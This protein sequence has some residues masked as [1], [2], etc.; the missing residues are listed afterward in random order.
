MD[1]SEL[2]RLIARRAFL[3]SSTVLGVGSTA[4][5]ALLAEENVKV[6]SNKNS[7]I[8]THFAP[9]AKSVIFL[10]MVGAPSQLDLF[11]PKPKLQE[12]HGKPAPDEFIEGKRFAFLRG[13]P[14]MMASPFE[15][16]KL[17]EGQ[18]IS[19]VLPHLKSVSQEI[20]II[21]S[22]KTEDFNH[23][24]AQMF[25][26]SGLNRIGRPS[27]GS[28][29]TYGLGSESSNLPAYVVMVSG[30]V[31]GAGATLWNNGFLPSMHQGVEFRSSG[32]PVLFFQIPK[33]L[34]MLKENESS[35]RLML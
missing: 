35:K 26:H 32:D 16:E 6:D 2:D 12:F 3:R 1:L 31:P 28:W 23:G 18:E 22:M 11:D 19:E 25:F 27:L 20:A 21:R 8:G 13:H 29:V 33:V 4:F 9:T 14:K 10:H 24:P 30:N 5:N 7:D 34:M 15:F 17:N